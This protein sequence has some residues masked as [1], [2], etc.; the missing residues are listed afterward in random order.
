VLDEPTN[1][2]DLQTLSVLEEFLDSFQ[3]VLVCVSH[4]R[5]FMERVLKLGGAS[6]QGN[7]DDNGDGDNDDDE[8]ND[9][10]AGSL[11][12]FEGNGKVRQ[13]LGSYSDYL[14]CE[15]DRLLNGGDDS[16]MEHF[17]STMLSSRPP[18]NTP[19]ITPVNT[20]VNTPV[21][22]SE[23]SP[24]RLTT[25]PLPPPPSPPPLPPPPSSTVD[26]P[27]L[28][29][30]SPRVANK[31][32]RAALSG[33]SSAMMMQPPTSSSVSSSGS[34]SHGTSPPGEKESEQNQNKKKNYKKRKK[35]VKL[36]NKERAEYE[37]IEEAVVAL[38]KEAADLNEQMST[39]QK[40][41]L[42]FTEQ[43]E[44]ASRASNARRDAD[45]MVERWM[46]LEAKVDEIAAERNNGSSS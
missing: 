43:A 28:Q 21:P 24:S 31:N 6:S 5:Y 4:D 42:S 18:V 30:S 16:L 45:A 33:T 39:A 27:P 13:F 9:S 17:A 15:K 1:D 34:S 2:L 14:A 37:R 3:G 12:V 10:P 26:S 35:S 23:A 38:E 25:T 19:V 20:P 41:G 8:D 44:V 7:D 22:S 36:T 32:N 46:E 11:F 29:P 40:R